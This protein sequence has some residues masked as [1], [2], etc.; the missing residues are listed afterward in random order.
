MKQIFLSLEAFMLTYRGI[1]N[2][3][4]IATPADDSQYLKHNI[5]VIEI[6]IITTT[7]MFSFVLLTILH[8][9]DEIS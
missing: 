3:T 7:C 6:I 5:M 4:C 8:Y 2:G 1:L 9:N